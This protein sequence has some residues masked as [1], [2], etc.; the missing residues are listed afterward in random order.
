VWAESKLV[1]TRSTATQFP[2][3]CCHQLRRGGRSL[4][5]TDGP[6]ART[7]PACPVAPQVLAA[8]DL[9]W[10]R[11]CCSEV[12]VGRTGRTRPG[13]V[14]PL[15]APGDNEQPDRFYC[16]TT[17]WPSRGS[18][19]RRCSRT[20]GLVVRSTAAS[21]ATSVTIA[22]GLSPKGRARIGSSGTWFRYLRALI[23]GLEQWH[24]GAAETGTPGLRLRS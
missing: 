3:P 21:G 9:Q 11:Q 20:Y 2:G 17:C 23:T 8:Y 24:Q 18:T 5:H 6:T 4:D 15:Q 14:R 7:E 16:P 13:P 19:G 1:A 22:R 10:A 12:R